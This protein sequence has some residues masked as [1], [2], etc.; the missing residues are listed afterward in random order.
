MKKNPAATTWG[1]G[2][3]TRMAQRLEGAAQRTVALAGVEEGER[4]LDVACGTGNA[5]LL[6]ARRG[7]VATGID[8]EP[9]LLE[10]ARERAGAEELEIAW[11]EGD[12]A[13]LPFDDGEFDVVLSVF[14]AMY[15]DDQ[16]AVAAEL[17]RV[18]APG[19]RLALAAWAPG[20]FLPT[21]GGA[22]AAYLP[23]PPAGSAPPARWGDEHSLAGLLAPAQIALEEMSREGVTLELGDR[24]QAVDFLIDTAGH[25]VAERDRLRAE[26]R[27]D[28]LV[29]DLGALVA[30]ADADDGKQISIRAEY[31]L[32]LGRVQ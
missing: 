20:T 5:A 4:V 27:W 3:Y 24:E 26:G 18:S 1:L 28:Q 11:R 10:V 14:G 31:L 32:A 7:A 15:A 17:R 8:I 22:L 25:V 16:A 19:A 29:A 2:E 6:A 21:M 30:G 12:A 23:P 13:Q 9:R